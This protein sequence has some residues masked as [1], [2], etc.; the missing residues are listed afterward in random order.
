MK[1]KQGRTLADVVA[2]GADHHRDV[3]FTFAAGVGSV[4]PGTS[5]TAELALSPGQY[6]ATCFVPGPSGQQHVA[7]GMVTPFTVR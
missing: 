7:M 3:P 4:A 5:A 6:L 2:Y 1:L